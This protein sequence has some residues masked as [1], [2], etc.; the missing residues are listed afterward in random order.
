MQATKC[1]YDEKPYEVTFTAKVISCE[2]KNEGE[3]YEVVL[4]QTMFFPEQGGQ[5]PDRGILGGAQVLDVQ[6]KDGVI[7]HKVNA[8]L[9]VGR[10]VEGEVDWAYRF[11]N[12]QQHTGEHIFSGSV[13]AKYGYQNVGFHL[14]DSSVTMDFDGPLSAEQVEELETIVNQR[15]YENI[16]VEASFPSDEELA[17]M[18]YR[19]KKELEGPIRIVT[20]PGVDVCA[21]CAPHVQHTGEIGIFKV[22][23]A[24]TYKG[25]V[26]ISFLCGYRALAAIRRQDEIV[27]ALTRQLSTNTEELPKRVKRLV[28]EEQQMRYERNQM[29]EQMMMEKI[30]ALPKG[31]EDVIFFEEGLEAKVMRN[32]VNDMVDKHPGICAVFSGNDESGYQFILGSQSRDCRQIANELRETFYAKGGGSDKMVQGNVEASEDAIRTFFAQ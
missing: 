3:T 8:S 6:I 7:T 5:T 31:Q 20:I 4:D 24:Q 17:R 21:C 30:N 29:K 14:S 27:T 32:L 26:R 1:L 12:M 22:M 9:E 13:Y 10:E 18:Q 25:G 23:N 15:I 16:A 28:S 2:K 11:S 19:S